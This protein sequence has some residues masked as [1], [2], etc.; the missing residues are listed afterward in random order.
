MCV[1]GTVHGTAGR[2][3]QELTIFIFHGAYLMLQ[4]RSKFSSA[5]L[6]TFLGS[7][8]LEAIVILVEIVYAILVFIYF[9]LDNK[10]YKDDESIQST[11][12]VIRIVELIILISLLVKLFF[13]TIAFG[14]IVRAP[15]LDLRHPPLVLH[16]AIFA[17]TSFLKT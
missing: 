4:P 10:Q 8:K 6:Q 14:F 13:R 5:C 15:G 9:A 3:R 16:S 1:Y 11:L 12:D 17:S 2:A 7:R